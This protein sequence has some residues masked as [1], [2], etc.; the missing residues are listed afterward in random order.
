MLYTYS[1]I[2]WYHSFFTIE[3][4]WTNN[5]NK[6]MILFWFVVLNVCINYYG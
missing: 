5:M 2:K 3:L 1:A 4:Q 6:H